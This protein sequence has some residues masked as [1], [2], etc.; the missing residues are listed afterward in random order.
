[1]HC[2]DTLLYVPNMQVVSLVFS[3]VVFSVHCVCVVSR[4]RRI[5]TSR[6]FVGSRCLP[7]IG[8][9]VPTDN[10]ALSWSSRRAA[11]QIAFAM[12]IFHEIGVVASP[13]CLVLPRVAR[14]LSTHSGPPLYSSI[15]IA[16]SCW[17]AAS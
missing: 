9:T 11:T 13:W 8:M 16:K 15:T 2:I 7:L 5:I 17:P 3:S 10:P 14:P 1:M 12:R 4:P 6:A